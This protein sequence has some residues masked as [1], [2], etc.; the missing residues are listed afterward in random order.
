[1][2]NGIEHFYVE[3]RASF[4]EQ[5]LVSEMDPRERPPCMCVGG[6]AH[7]SRGQHV[8]NE[9]LDRELPLCIVNMEKTLGT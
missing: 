9:Y 6:A 8:G 3:S 5:G 7:S 2:T 4:G 1:M